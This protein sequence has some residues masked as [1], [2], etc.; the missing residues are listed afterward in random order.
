VRREE[1]LRGRGAFSALYREGFRLE[2]KVIRCFF[3]CEEGAGASVRAGFSVSGRQ[4]GAVMRNRLK[5]L[6][7]AAFDAEKSVIG[8]RVPQGRI[9]AL[10]VYRGSQT[11][12][13]DRLHLQD[14]RPDMEQFC[15]ALAA[16]KQ[17][18]RP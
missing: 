3:R 15:R 17:G 7:R 2:G 12:P 8:T 18:H 14:I 11:K 5:R 9:T 13:A 6:M 1:T 10:F 4:C 16:A